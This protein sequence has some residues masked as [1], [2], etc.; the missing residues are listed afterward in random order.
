MVRVIGAGLGRTGT[1]ALKLALCRLG[2]GPC[3]HFTE[4][5][6]HPEHLYAWA[7]AANGE[8][9]AWRDPLKEYA[10]TTDWPGVAFWRELV[11]AFPGAKVIL[12]T[13]DAGLWFESMNE[14][15][16]AAMAGRFPDA[17]KRYRTFEAAEQL[18][19]F[20]RA[21]VV[22]RTFGGRIDDRD[23]VIA[24]YERHNDEVRRTVAP[25]R[26]LDFRVSQGWEPLCA[27]LG[28]PIPG[29]PFP[30]ANERAGFAETVLRDPGAGEPY[31]AG[32]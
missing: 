26:L 28:V 25:G 2:F 24:C 21:G 12:T 1:M 9:E 11:E 17:A 10:A 14:T 27:F 16:F 5:F 7:A 18:T 29:E 30:R 8:P 19:E 3:Y 20:G 32:S 15:V 13:R 23:H 4:V 31:P 6:A 22:G